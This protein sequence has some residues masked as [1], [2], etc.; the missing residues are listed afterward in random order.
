MTKIST[1]ALA[2][3][4]TLLIT[5]CGE[6]GGDDHVDDHSDGTHTHAD[7]TVHKDGDHADDT[8]KNDDHDHGEETELP[9]ATIGDMKVELAQAHGAIQ[10]G[11]EGHLVVKLPYKDKGETIVRAW[12]G[13]EDRTLSLVGKGE[14]AASHDDYDIHTM[15]PDPLPENVM[16]WVEIEKPDGTKVVGSTI[17]HTE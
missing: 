11:K 15:A 8:N 14:Y 13:T 5:G 10:A 16:W 6:S 2:L 1:F 7:G 17:P 9:A 3:A 12:I 4:M